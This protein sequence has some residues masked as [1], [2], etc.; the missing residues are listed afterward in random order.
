MRR[1][2]L[3]MLILC[4]SFFLLSSISSDPPQK[5]RKPVDPVGY[6]IRASQ[7]DS[8]M[9]RIQKLEGNKMAAAWERY[10][11]DKFSRWSVAICPHDDYTYSGWLYPVVLR[12]INARTVI[13][14]G[15]AHKAKRF[16]IEDK[17]V[18]DSHTWWQGPYGQ[19][20]VSSVRERIM[21]QLP[22]SAYVVNDSLQ[23]TEHSLEALIP[24]LQYFNSKV[25]IVP[26]LVPAMSFKT[27]DGIAFTLATAVR[28]VMEEGTLSWRDDLA[29]VISNDAVHY[30]D[31]AWGGQ[32]YAIYGSD[33]AGYK[34]ALVHEYEIIGNC[35]TGIITKDKIRR[36]TGYTVQ[37]TNYRV[38]KWTWC[39]RYS[40]PLGLLT[41]YYIQQ[42]LRLGPLK[43]NLLGYSTSIGQQPVPVD[44][45][46]MGTTAIATLHHWVGYAAIGYR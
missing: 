33:S 40:V 20:R 25:E 26:I 5:I 32:N 15:V 42:N 24:Y 12:N 21:N 45:L 16:G 22:R 43:G 35:L 31:E 18:F 13:L 34:K 30:G 27:M 38:Y 1:I 17:L 28:K 7:M 10:N 4:C 29:I 19:A 44:D 23:E 39:G 3:F 36:F 14:I 37:D 41:G 11:L 9:Q 6:A 46:Q 8:L 2:I